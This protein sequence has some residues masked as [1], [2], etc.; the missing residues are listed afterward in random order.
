MLT[1]DKRIV[2]LA[3]LVGV[4]DYTFNHVAFQVYGLIQRVVGHV[5]LYKVA[6]AVARTKL[7]TVVNQR[8]TGVEERIVFH[9]HLNKIVAEGI[10]YKNRVVGL[11]SNERAVLS[12]GFRFHYSAFFHHLATLKACV[13]GH[14]VTPRLHVAPLAQGIGGF[15]AHTIHTHRALIVLC[16]ELTAGVHGGGGT[17]DILQRYAAAI[18]ANAHLAVLHGEF[19]YVAVAG[20]VLVDGVVERFLEQ[21]IYAVV[22]LRTVTQLTYIHTRSAPDVLKRRQGD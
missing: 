11:K 18:V 13:G 21:H 14:P 12:I 19:D 6:Q 2:F 10:A 20:S 5:F 3:V 22:V 1:I 17:G 7:A 9:H 4:S 8:E 16:V 15:Q